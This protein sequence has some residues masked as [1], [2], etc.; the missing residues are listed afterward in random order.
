[1]FA[2]CTFFGIIPS[3]KT[4]AQESA[5]FCGTY[6]SIGDVAFIEAHIAGTYRNFSQRMAASGGTIEIPVQIHIACPSNDPVSCFPETA[7][8]NAINVLNAL[9]ANV[10]MH[11]YECADRN[12]I[13]E[14][15]GVVNNNNL[16]EFTLCSPHDVAGVVNIY[17]V[18]KIF[19]NPPS[20]ST[21]L[22]YAPTTPQVGADRI[23]IARR[24]ITDD[25]VLYPD[26]ILVHEMAHF[27]GVYHTHGSGVP[28]ATDELVNGSNCNIAGDEIC[29]TPADPANMAFFVTHIT[30]E[31]CEYPATLS[32][33]CCDANGENYSPLSNNIMFAYYCV[34]GTFNAFTD[35]QYSRIWDGY[36]GFRSYL[37]DA[38]NLAMR[39]NWY[40]VGQE[41]NYTANDLLE[42]EDIWVSPDLW[43][44]IDDPNC[45]EH[46]DPEYKASGGS[47]YLRVRITNRGC[48][49]TPEGRKLHLYWTRARTGETW[50]YHWL[51]TPLNQTTNGHPLGHMIT[52][53]PSD[54][55]QA[56]PLDIPP[57]NPEET[58]VITQPWQAPNPQWYDGDD[59]FSVGASPMLCFLAR[60]TGEIATSPSSIE[61]EENNIAVGY[62]VKA[63][64]NIVTRN[65]ALTDLDPLNLNNTPRSIIIENINNQLT[66]TD[67][68]LTD[69]T[70]NTPNP[71]TNYGSI[72]LLLDEQLWNNWQASG[73][74]SA[75]LTY[76]EYDRTLRVTDAQEAT[77]YDIPFESGEQRQ[78]AVR[79]ELAT[80]SG[81]KPEILPAQ[82]QHYSF[83]LWH[84]STLPAEEEML[85]GGGIFEVAIH[86]RP[87]DAISLTAL[88]VACH[89]N[90]IQGNM[91]AQIQFTM[92]QSAPI[93]VD[94]YDI[95]GKQISCITPSQTYQKGTHLLALNPQDLPLKSGMY[96]CRITTPQGYGGCKIAVAR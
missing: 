90:P 17:F 41:P 80:A 63:S 6:Y 31:Y 34:Y 46:Q 1:M 92:L 49:P 69:I 81:K 45:T 25:I 40:D 57:L 60:I 38:G 35:G 93:R 95:N 56:I 59:G 4:N 86:P 87:L 67:V 89:P 10:P 51:H 18:D 28:G 70:R 24:T 43:N 62:N 9:Y 27:F 26:L 44:C 91:P 88:P 19:P 16:S 7:I 47:N 21:P 20:T 55:L 22:G 71:F 23:F 65:C 50:I 8:D 58:I 85:K 74:Q 72:Y 77:L 96:F 30:D 33:Y 36:Y 11:F 15:A 64:N 13:Y 84:S 2:F 53:N 79:F 29:D 3:F 5:N 12:Y 52:S 42:W 37:S 14:T 68:H 39:D 73:G 82:T 94:I 61:G 48:S 54:P 78:I 83:Y 66:L 75:G 76:T 32:P